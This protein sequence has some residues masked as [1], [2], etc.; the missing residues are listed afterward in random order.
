MPSKETKCT[1]R[2]CR[3]NKA[4]QGGYHLRYCWKCKSRLLKQRHPATYF[5]N[6]LRQSAT[7]RGI[8]CSLT[9]AQF[10]AFCDSTGF[11]ALKGKKPDDATIDRIDWNNGYHI[12]NI[13]VLPHG[14]NS[15]QGKYNIPR[16]LRKQLEQYES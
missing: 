5:L 15:R 14:K 2:Y 16:Y 6:T 9:V 7:K 8:E 1:T 10:K 3:N 13:R 4:V 12:N 11:L